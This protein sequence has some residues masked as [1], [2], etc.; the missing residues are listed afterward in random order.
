MTWVDLL[1]LPVEHRDHRVLD[2]YVSPAAAELLKADASRARAVLQCWRGRAVVPLDL[3]RV[4]IEV[5]VLDQFTVQ[6]DLDAR[7]L[8]RDYVLVPLRR[9]VDLLLR[10]DRLVDRAG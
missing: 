3:L 1:L 7:A 2:H 10:R 5:H 4:L 9:L 8:R 6:L